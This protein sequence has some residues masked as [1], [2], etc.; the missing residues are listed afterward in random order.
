MWQIGVWERDEGLAERVSRLAEGTQTLV[1]ACRH[2][3]L[4]AGLTLDLLI[5]SPGATGW[6]GAGALNCRTALL[7]GGR[8]ALTRALP[9]GVVL[10]YGASSRNTLTLSSLDGQRASV[11]VQREFIDLDGKAVDRQELVL[12]YDG[13]SPDLLLAEAGVALLLGRLAE[14]T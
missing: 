9:A 12:P 6:A 10:S 14:E 3:A 4:L 8:S 7:P 13:G 11:A 2:P 1:R 5:V